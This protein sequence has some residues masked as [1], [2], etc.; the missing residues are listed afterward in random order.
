M[1]NEDSAGEDSFSNQ[2]LEYPQYSRPEVWHDKQVPPVLL[3]GHHGKV[4]AW[5][6]EQ[7]LLRTFQ[8]RPE[9]LERA[10]LTEQDW[11]FIERLRSVEQD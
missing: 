8:R 2:L 11:K 9:L 1:N 10:E 4:D 7:S 5:R 6:R 3:S